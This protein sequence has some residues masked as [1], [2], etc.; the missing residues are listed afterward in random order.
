M[1]TQPSGKLLAKQRS[2]RLKGAGDTLSMLSR[3]VNHVLLEVEQHQLAAYE[4]D[5]EYALV[6][7]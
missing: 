1:L 6:W 3:L 4:E 5:V 7:H 2:Q